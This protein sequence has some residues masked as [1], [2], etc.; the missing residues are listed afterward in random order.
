MRD[1]RSPEIRRLE[2]KAQLCFVLNGVVP[3]DVASDLMVHGVNMA[4]L[5][6]RIER[7]TI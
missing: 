6:R 5:E 7:G 3:L 4:A 1:M 2:R